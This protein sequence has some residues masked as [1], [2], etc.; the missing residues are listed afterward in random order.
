MDYAGY[1]PYLAALFGALIG[2]FLNVVIVR[3]PKMCFRHWQQEA[4]SFLQSHE[5]ATLSPLGLTT[6]SP[7]EPGIQSVNLIHPRSQCPHCQHLIRAWDN[8]PI[9]SFC[10][11]RGKCRDCHQ[12]IAWRYPVIEFLT[13]LL[14][15]WVARHF[16]W[17]WTALAGLL[18]T[19]VLIVQTAIDLEHQL[20]FDELTLPM[21][22]LGLLL[23]LHNTFVSPPESILGTALGYGSLWSLY[24]LFKW[25]TRKEGMGYGDFKLFALCGAWFGYQSLLSIILT[26]SLLGSLVGLALIAFR[27]HDKH[28]PIP[29]GPFLA[30]GA[31]L[32]LVNRDPLSWLWQSWSSV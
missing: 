7:V 3:Y 29:F 18:L 25:A 14:S 24:W 5:A 31:W 8:I 6:S 21:L 4:L 26:A 30:I 2:S 17:G 19:W 9:L 23:S 11:L 1:F 13:A 20:L 15:F 16:G 28:Q 10:L 32:Y 27:G 22:W 12:A